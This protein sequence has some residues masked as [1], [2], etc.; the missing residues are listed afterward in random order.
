MQSG[1]H[2]VTGASI[3]SRASWHSLSAPISYPHGVA[4][5]KAVCIAWV[6]PRLPMSTPTRNFKSVLMWWRLIWVVFLTTRWLGFVGP[7]RNCKSA[8]NH[9]LTWFLWAHNCK[10]VLMRWILVPDSHQSSFGHTTDLVSLNRVMFAGTLKS[11]TLTW[12]C[13]RYRTGM[14]YKTLRAK[15]LWYC[16]RHTFW[17]YIYI[18]IYIYKEI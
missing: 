1:L 5:R 8:L 17:L 18:Y 3:E 12:C 10:S 15:S 9:A 11:T 14:P 13:T 6:I 7:T 2:T 16:P 4:A